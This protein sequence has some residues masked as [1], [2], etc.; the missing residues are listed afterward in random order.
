MPNFEFKCQECESVTTEFFKIADRPEVI[1]CDCGGT[2]KFQLSA[3]NIM[4]TALPD[5]TK[6]KGWAEMR[7]ASKINKQMANEKPENRKE[8]AK[9]IRKLGVKF[10]K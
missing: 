10:D 5:G 2:A 6:R 9:E 4:G 3:P 8:M 7:E 1:T